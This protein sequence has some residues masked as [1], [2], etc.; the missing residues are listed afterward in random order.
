MM[1]SERLFNPITLSQ[2]FRLRRKRGMK[3]A[4]PVSSGQWSKHK[5]PLGAWASS[6]R[7]ERPAI[8][9]MGFKVRQL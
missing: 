9:V 8:H 1:N 3:R 6:E 5:T 7:S 4:A 2:D